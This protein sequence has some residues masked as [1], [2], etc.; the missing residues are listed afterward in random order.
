MLKEEKGSGRE[1]GPMDGLG[2]PDKGS[3]LSRVATH[4]HT[5]TRR[6]AGEE[7]KGTA[8]PICIG[9]GIEML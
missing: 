7:C 2:E 8:A 5:H 4:T 6:K 1:V 9:D 3:S